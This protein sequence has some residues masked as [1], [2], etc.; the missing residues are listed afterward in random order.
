VTLHDEESL[1]L[2]AN[3]IFHLK[4]KTV[5]IRLTV[6][7][8]SSYSLNP[9]LCPVAPEHPNSPALFGVLRNLSHVSGKTASLEYTSALSDAA[10]VLKDTAEAGS[11]HEAVEGTAAF[12]QL[13]TD[14][15]GKG[16]FAAA[17][18]TA[19]FQGGKDEFDAYM[20]ASS[21]Q[22]LSSGAES[23]LIA[24]KVLSNKIQRDVQALQAGRA[25]LDACKS[26]KKPSGIWLRNDG[27]QTLI[28]Q[29]GSHIQ[30]TKLTINDPLGPPAGSVT[31]YG[32]YVSSPFQAMGHRTRTTSDGQLIAE[33][34]V[35]ERLQVLDRN[36][37]VLTASDSKNHTYTRATKRAKY[38]TSSKQ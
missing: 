24:L 27:E 22:S 26:P 12:F 4:S 29:S 2:R 6:G 1:K 9:V 34:W 10:K 17:L 31:W 16:E 7:K 5:G 14:L 11:S 32:E 37:L 25:E 18:G 21:V 15:A 3:R 35:T 33:F 38:V 36:T 30:A 19:L 20:I 13:A 28:Q 8:E 23:Q